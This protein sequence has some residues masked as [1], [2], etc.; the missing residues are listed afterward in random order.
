VLPAL[1][2]VG[3]GLLGVPVPV[4]DPVVLGGLL[5]VVALIGL[6]LP[7]AAA[8]RATRPSAGGLAARAG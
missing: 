6:T 4:L 7:V 2:G 3:Q 5:A 8:V 1:L